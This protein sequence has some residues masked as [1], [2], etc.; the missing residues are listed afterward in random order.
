MG[1]LLNV[2]ASGALVLGLGLAGCGGSEST[3]SSS[4]PTASAS[5][6]SSTTQSTATAGTPTTTGAQTSKSTSSGATSASGAPKGHSRKDT[7]KL[8]SSAF[9]VGGAIPA[10]YTCDGAN[11]SLPLQWRS[12]PAGTA[13]LVLFVSDIEGT[14]PGGGEL[15]SWA[16]A[17]LRPSLKGIAAGRVP[18]G[19]VVGRNS[20]GKVG[21]TICPAKGSPVQHYL[22][23]LYPL[24]RSLAPK[25]G[26]DANAFSKEASQV[27]ENEGLTGFS[28][29]RA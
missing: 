23:V 26:F 29:K 13:E 6:T 22:V 17:G 3:Q 1:R 27:A 7:L 21:Y 15:I 28:Y 18:A 8:S 10:R 2:A 25:A 12:I 5:K 20:F 19:A 14:A 4:A 16:V 24:S 11:V 9:T